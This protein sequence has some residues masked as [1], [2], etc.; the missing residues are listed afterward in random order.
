M[1]EVETATSFWSVDY[2]SWGVAME[3]PSKEK[4]GGDLLLQFLAFR[5]REGCN[6]ERICEAREIV[7]CVSCLDLPFSKLLVVNEFAKDVGFG[8]E[9]GLFN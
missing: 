2:C 5:G 8:L 3:A 6:W 7:K 4:A 9:P 1:L